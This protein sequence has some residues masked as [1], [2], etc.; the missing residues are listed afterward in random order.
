MPTLADPASSSIPALPAEVV[1]GRPTVWANPGLAP[2]AAALAVTELGPLDYAEACAN[3]DA[4]APLLATIFA[5]LESTDGRIDSPLLAVPTAAAQAI[6]GNRDR[7]L[8]KADHLLPIA[9]S[10][11]ARGGFYEVL[12]HARDLAHRHG[13]LP[14]GASPAILS[15]PEARLLFSGHRVVTGSTGNLGFSIG[16]VGR[17]LGFAVDVHMSHDAK[18]WKKDRLR[19]GGVNVIEHAGDYGL[20]V[21]EARR[22]AQADPQSY[23]VDDEDSERLFLGYSA[24]AACLRAQ[25]I[26]QGV[27]SDEEHPLCVYLPCG[28]GGAPGGITFGLKQE[29]GDAVTC[30]LVEPVAS[31]CMLI[32]LAAGPEHPVS[33]YDIGLDNRT[34][35][36]GLAVAS[37]SLLAAGLIQGLVSAVVTVDDASLLDWV[38][39]SHRELGLRVEPSAASGFAAAQMF[40]RAG[41]PAEATHVIWTTGGGLLPDAEFNALLA[42]GRHQPQGSP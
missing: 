20:A 40:K 37:A 33:V 29:F 19:A 15:R 23:F 25:L 31:P 26:E 2:A 5:E 41:A 8:V 17:A 9:G 3:W 11:K 30:V 35:A 27:A 10:I 36:D 4:L 22:S 7:V 42:A 18:A 16:L 21:R 1:A 14:V 32:Q 12:I 6:V 24:A 28:V 13:L 39:W 38:G 34:I